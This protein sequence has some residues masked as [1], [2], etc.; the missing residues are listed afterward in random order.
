MKTKKRDKTAAD[1]FAAVENLIFCS[2]DI[3]TS[4]FDPAESE[5][6]ELGM[7][8]FEVKKKNIKVLSEWQSVFKPFKEVPPRIL[9]LTGI[10]E[11]ELLRAPL[12]REKAEDI[13][14]LV[15]DAVIVG[16][17]IN[18]DIKFLE[19]FGIKFSGAVVDTL[20]LAQ[21]FLPTNQ[22]YNLEG[23]MNFLGVDHQD[24]HRALADAKAALVLVEKLL[25]C[26][27]FLPKNIKG[28]LAELFAVSDK[29]G[30][31]VLALLQTEFVPLSIEM[32][33]KLIGIR[34]SSEIAA[35]MKQKDKIL[36]FP[37]GF[38]YHDY[39]YGSLGKTKD[40]FLLVVP[41]K[42]TVYQL[43][44]QK[45]A[46]PFFSNKEVFNQPAFDRFA[47]KAKTAEER[48]FAGKIMVWQSI[49]WQ[50]K[51][52]VD[53]NLNFGSQ[54]K[55]QIN[56]EKKK[57]L[58]WE[59][60]TSAKTVVVDYNDF[61]NYDL[62]KIY[63]GRKLLI[64]DL[65]NFEQALTALTTKRTGWGDFIY[66]FRQIYDPSTG[67]GRKVA[68]ADIAKAQSQVDLFFGMAGIELAKIAKGEQQFSITSEI[69]TGTE[70]GKI[71]KSAEN[72]ADDIERE[73]KNICSERITE[74]VLQLRKFFLP[75]PE[76]VRWVEL[77]ENRLAFIS[78]PLT[79]KKI[80]AKKIT[81]FAD[82]VFT[83]SLGSD[84]LIQYFVSRLNLGGFEILKIGQQ[85]LR[86][87]FQVIIRK[88]NFDVTEMN[89]LLPK[90]HYPAAVLLPN[91]TVL[92]NY[93]EANYK[94]LQMQYKVS[95]QTYSGGGNKMLDN[96]SINQNALLLVTDHFVVK[97]SHKRIKVKDL[98]M[99]RLPFEHFN[100]PLFAAQAQL[101]AN[102]FV[103]FNIPRALNNFHSIIRSFYTEELERIYI[104]DS[105]INKEYGKYFVDYL[106]SLPFVEIRYE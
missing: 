57:S 42:Q 27:S 83:A 20:N 41:D 90:L 85:E 6:L 71:K 70:F 102:Q 62:K 74:L 12:F 81:P 93:Y 101:Y 65:N 105:K 28:R 49:N 72:F 69:E 14:K 38:R 43:W 99:M 75:D 39:I 32:K 8:F 23:L 44:K 59:S 56:Y 80:A 37:L 92:K 4:G 46:Y 96:F 22:S 61:I 88:K 21:M 26:Y 31:A 103:D 2:L 79:L 53:L 87:K 78:S 3:E 16:H 95:A 91:Q 97:H 47:R 48:F 9:A 64:V 86:K 77:G 15:K 45:I 94:D 58:V 67:S 35:A 10:S 36:S 82:S 54:Y 76:Q 7:V 17:N 68:A 60:S 66:A 25:S 5:V 84:A 34:Q 104:L 24:A 52:L 100:H 40:K 1:K 51:V 30:A 29:A 19:A 11:D 50:S 13:Q 98:V 106:Q 63:F 18:F 73:N 33:S 55:S 89:D